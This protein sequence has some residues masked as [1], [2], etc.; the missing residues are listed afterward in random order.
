MM[1]ALALAAAPSLA[2]PA[3]PAPLLEVKRTSL[4]TS[5]PGQQSLTVEVKDGKLRVGTCARGVC[6]TE[7]ELAVPERFRAGLAEARLDPI[8]LD[9]RRTVARVAV[10]DAGAGQTWVALLAGPLKA[11]PAL[12]LFTGPA[13]L[14][15][16]PAASE[17]SLIQVI[18]DDGRHLVVGA[19]SSEVQLCGRPSVLSPRLVD[20]A[21]LTL[22]PAR[23]QR[24]GKKERGDAQRLIATAA[25]AGRPAPLARMLRALGASSGVG[26]PAAVTDGDA[27]TAWSEARGSDGRG[28]FVAMRS[29][30]DAP[31]T[32][33]TVTIRPPT[34][35]VEHGAAPRRFYLVDDTATFEVTLPEDAWQKPGASYQ[36]SFPT[37][38]ATGCLALILEDSYVPR[39][40]ASPAVTVAEVEA[41]SALDGQ[42]TLDELVSR[43]EQGGNAAREASALLVRG[44]NAARAAIERGYAQ[45][46]EAA[47]LQALDAIDQGSCQESSPFYARLLS[48]KL[49][50]EARHARSR[51]ERCGKGAVEALTAATRD[52]DHPSRAAAANELALL[53]P[54][55]AIPAL[56]RAAPGTHRRA[57]L[58]ALTKAASAPRG[59]AVLAAQLDDATLP[60][61]ATLDLLRAGD[62]SLSDP[63]VRDPAARALGRVVTPTAGFDERYLALR[64]A[65][66]LAAL[67]DATSLALLGGA[68]AD[69]S[70][71]LRASAAAES[72]PVLA[73]RP[74]LLAMTSDPE[75]RVRLAIARA[76][77]GQSGEAERK[78]LLALLGD[79]WTFVRAATYDALATAGPDA[80]VDAALVAKLSGDY[81]P[82]ALARAIEA[83]GKR[84]VGAAADR[85]RALADDTARPLDIRA[86]SVQALGSVCHRASL[87]WLTELARAGAAPLSDN[88]AQSLGGSA[89]VALGRLH[90]PDLATRLAPLLGRDAPRVVAMAARAALAETDTCP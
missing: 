51:I 67:G 28:E 52:T 18:E 75:P 89:L 29:S 88:E 69:P 32:S 82:L 76:L 35:A 59:R 85:L 13:D 55:D 26:S 39:D 1:F 49:A 8:V 87:D 14:T 21:D 43:L 22:K 10:P 86:R 27:E 53:S 30:R 78:A 11:G 19:R 74:R 61:R 54:T 77:L 60:A 72:G 34:R 63:A 73:L 5:G 9:N 64:P 70:L 31:I 62:E 4:T 68:L 16:S 41:R 57:L 2:Q 65:G 71:P 37:P 81:A 90:P 23:V 79:E 84:R 3:R 46:G 40:E 47:R 48:S 20:P 33:L 24:L 80:A 44:G 17:P 45:L 36:I 15:G 6:A 66:R 42:M 58:A 7:S 12:E 50:P 56:V 83:L 38:R 25:P